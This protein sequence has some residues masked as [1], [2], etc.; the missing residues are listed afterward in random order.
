MMMSAKPVRVVLVEDHVIM[1]S[2][3]KQLVEGIGSCKIVAEAGCGAEAI[4]AVERHLPDLVL[5]DLSLPRMDGLEVL[6]IIRP[7]S[8]GKILV[9]TVFSNDELLRQAMDLGA[10]GVILKDS[11][12]AALESGIMKA[13]EELESR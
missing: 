5:L 2:L 6:K 13:L 7:K 12:K 11:G 1:R 8:R 9:I 4:D 10:D 3:L